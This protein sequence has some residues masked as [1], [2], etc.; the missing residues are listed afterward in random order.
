MKKYPITTVV[1]LGGYMATA[2]YVVDRLLGGAL[3]RTLSINQV[4]PNVWCWVAITATAIAFRMAGKV[5]TRAL[6]G[7]VICG[8]GMLAVP[9]LYAVLAEKVPTAQGFYD[10]VVKATL[11]S[12]AAMIGLALIIDWADRVDASRNRDASNQ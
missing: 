6:T 7:G 11:W 8:I 1:V 10:V 12:H 2:F 3:S 9:D 5:E 4:A